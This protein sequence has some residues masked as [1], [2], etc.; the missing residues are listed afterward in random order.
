MVLSSQGGEAMANIPQSTNGFSPV[1]FY[2]Q[3]AL[4]RTSHHHS[5]NEH[6][7]TR[8]SKAELGT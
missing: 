6:F 7:K 1:N 8:L 2:N 3:I 4:P 5:R